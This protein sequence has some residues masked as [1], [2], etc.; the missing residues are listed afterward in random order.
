MLS[1]MSQAFADEFQQKLLGWYALE[2]RDELLWRKNI[3][4]YSVWLSEVMLQQTQVK[5]VIPYFEHFIREYPTVSDL[6]I[7]NRDKILSSWSGLGYYSRARNLHE[8]AKIISQ[9]YDGKFPDNPQS[10]IALPGIGKSTAHAILAIAYQK[11]FGILD[12]NV[13]RVLSRI[14]CIKE[15]HTNHLA[16]QSLWRHTEHLVSKN[17]PRDYTQAI[18]DL[19]ALI[20]KRIAPQC[21]KCPLNA[22]CKAHKNQC[23][24][25][26]PEKKQKKILPIKTVNYGLITNTN[27]HILLKKRPDKGLWAGLW[28]C[29]EIDTPT[30]DVYFTMKHRFTHFQLN[31]TVYQYPAINWQKHDSEE[32]FSQE[33]ISD[34]GLPKPFK[35]LT[36]RYFSEKFP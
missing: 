1:L 22:L 9:Q 17:N 18:M 24:A 11:P 29:P 2:G 23:T 19:G 25:E 34:I 8:T 20:C 28:Q 7:A 36:E 3:S 14:F 26:Y 15:I 35:L 31:L 5:T 4:P 27:H 13:K 16:L 32:W 6:A 33:T 12:G 10:L 30:E 21:D